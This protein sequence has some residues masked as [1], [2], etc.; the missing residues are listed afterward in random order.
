LREIRGQLNQ[1]V[2]KM[3]IIRWTPGRDLVG[4]QDEMNRL[5]DNFFGWP[6]RGNDTYVKRWAPRVN[7][8][9]T[10]V[11]FELTAE[12]PGME[13]DDINIEVQDNTLTIRGESKFENE[14][15]EKN[16][17]LCERCYGEFTRTFTLPDNVDTDKIDAE[18]KNGILKLEI[19][20]TEKALPKE[21]KVKVK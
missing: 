18:Y 15:K 2:R 3:A 7:I 4:I 8:E 6:K 5:F 20:K 14:K 11:K 9:E 16:Y 12:L 10:D 1:E 13:K 21:I 17:H 19:P